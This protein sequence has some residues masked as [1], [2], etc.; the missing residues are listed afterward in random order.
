MG[1]SHRLPLASRYFGRQ[2][3]QPIYLS[4]PHVA[5]F[6]CLQI[7][8]L[9]LLW[10]GSLPKPIF[11]AALVPALVES[12]QSDF[13][14]ERVASVRTLLKQVCA[15]MSCGVS[16]LSVVQL[17]AQQRWHLATACD[18]IL[19]WLLLPQCLCPV[20]CVAADT[21]SAPA[22]PPPL[23]LAGRAVCR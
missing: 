2:P 9:L 5:S 17:A 13:Y 11:P 1:T 15:G 22:A 18:S 23:P 10:L 14:E 3:A 6:V 8:N 4:T 21:L 20:W 7:A 16:V 12:Q 19:R